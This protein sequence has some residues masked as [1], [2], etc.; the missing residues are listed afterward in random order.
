MF[1][2]E[3]DDNCP[4]SRATVK[5]TSPVIIQRLDKTKEKPNG[6]LKCTEMRRMSE[7]GE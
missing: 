7:E 2:K 3:D 4:G 5:R 6:F 1:S